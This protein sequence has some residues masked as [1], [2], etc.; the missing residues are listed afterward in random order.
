MIQKETLKSRRT[1]EFSEN[2]ECEREL[3]LQDFKLNHSSVIPL[4]QISLLYLVCSHLSS[5][6]RPR[7]YTVI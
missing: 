6:L 7:C 1:E 3:A 2:R 4:L 5:K